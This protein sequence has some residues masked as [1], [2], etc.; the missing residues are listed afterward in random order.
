MKPKYMEQ[1]MKL[2]DSII[3]NMF[4]LEL[5]E[6]ISFLRN[7]IRLLWQENQCRYLETEE[8]LRQLHLLYDDCIGDKWEISIPVRIRQ[9]IML[10]CAPRY[11]EEFTMKVWCSLQ[12]QN[13]RRV[14]EGRETL[15]GI[16]IH[17]PVEIRQEEEC[18]FDEQ[19]A[20]LEDMF[21]ESL[22]LYGCM[23]RGN[24]VLQRQT[25]AQQLETFWTPTDKQ[26]FTRH[27]GLQTIIKN[28]LDEKRK[29]SADNSENIAFK[30]M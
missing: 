14:R 10:V 7:T 21:S 18:A 12:A 4:L 17:Y 16:W 22:A 28:Q 29:L 26:F 13:I 8:I 25:Y 24:A 2:M 11:R 15:K 3:D 23:I 1:M 30:L 6:P 27:A 19:L 9:I 20:M 5:L